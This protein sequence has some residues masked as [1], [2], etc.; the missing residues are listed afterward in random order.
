MN[1]EKEIRNIISNTIKTTEPIDDF[2]ADQCLQNIGLDSVTFI[3][4][5]VEIENRFEFEFPDEKLAITE[6][7]TIRKLCSVVASAK[8]V[9]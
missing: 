6:V 8:G 7:E 3:R 2:D 5:V 9:T 4:I 1:Y